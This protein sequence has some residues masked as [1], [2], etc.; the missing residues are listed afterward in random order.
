[1]LEFVVCLHA[2][3]WCKLSPTPFLC[4]FQAA[5]QIF[6]QCKAF[7]VSLKYFLEAGGCCI[8]LMGIERQ[9]QLRNLHS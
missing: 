1:M 9:N 4:A 7:A 2:Q 8:A 6:A 5:V 3:G